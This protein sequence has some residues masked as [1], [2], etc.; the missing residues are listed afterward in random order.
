MNCTRQF[1]L[2]PR[3]A[4]FLRQLAAVLALFSPLLSADLAA[5]NERGVAMGHLHFKVH[6]VEA[7]EKFW[8]GLGGKA[9]GFGEMR[10]ISFPDIL[11][12]LSPGDYSGTSN[13]SVVNHVAFRVDSIERLKN[14]GTGIAD[15]PGHPGIATLHTPDGDKIEFFDERATNVFFTVA[16]DGIDAVAADVADRHNHPIT[17][18]IT[19]HHLHFYIPKEDVSAARNWYVEHFGGLAGKRWEYEAADFPGIN[20]NFSE[21]KEPVSPTR[22]RLVDH[23]GF[24]V[25]DLDAFCKQLAEQDILCESAATDL[26]TGVKSAFLTDPWGS[27]IELTQ[28]L[29]TIH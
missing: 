20:L 8:T 3:L 4:V 5:P 6:D 28:G 16:D 14:D 22:G 13:G 29:N 18:P 25:A 27:Y 21:A 7:N 26:P 23:I 1:A 19:S 17:L 12:V 2:A 11:I 9:V 15:Y 10:I 24:E